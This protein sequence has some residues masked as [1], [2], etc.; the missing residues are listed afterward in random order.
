MKILASA[1]AFLL[2]GTLAVAA[3]NPPLVV[4]A[5]EAMAR[6]DATWSYVKTTTGNT[7]ARAEHFDPSLPEESRW[8]L[9]EIAG[10]TPTADERAE[11]AEEREAERM[12]ANADHVSDGK[13]ADGL[14]RDG[15]LVLLRE[16]DEQVVYSFRPF[17]GSAVA[18]FA[19]AMKGTLTIAKRYPHAFTIEMRN[20]KP[21]A[22]FTGFHI[23]RIFTRLVFRPV[24]PDGPVLPY[25]LEATL[26]ARAMTVKRLDENS[27]IRF[28][29]YKKVAP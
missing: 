14:I 15:S 24:T 22:P 12:F 4:E 6:S 7:R 25:E 11:Y 27:V 21:V 26:R 20:E 29:Q 2:A 18:E 3:D 5:L 1:T 9:L 28:T 16:N 10:R 8:T 23:N 17:V 19:E 13:V